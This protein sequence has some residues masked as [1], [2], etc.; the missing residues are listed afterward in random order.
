LAIIHIINN[1]VS[2]AFVADGV[3]AY[4]G[5]PMMSENHMEFDAIHKHSSALV[6][7]LGMINPEK[8]V[9]MIKACHSAVKY[10][11]PIG[12]DPVGIHISPWRL[13]VFREIMS[14]FKIAFV[15]GNQDE[16]YCGIFGSYDGGNKSLEAEQHF[17]LELF[18]SKLLES[19]VVWLITGE[20]D[21][22][23]G[24]GRYEVIAGGT[25]ALRKISGAGCLLSAL[26][27][28]NLSKGLCVY[29]AAVKASCDL[30]KASEGLIEGGIGTLK[31]KIIDQLG[32]TGDS[33]V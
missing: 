2:R 18:S 23:I 5:S 4:G 9:L 8:K 21:Y 28:V 25:P 26:V 13:E 15:K 29:N 7:N 30:K 19:K 24:R 6:I 17:E 20:K 12:V 32:K 3:L 33:N 14:T 1:E 16:V 10:G 27:A 22:V 11:I 31:I